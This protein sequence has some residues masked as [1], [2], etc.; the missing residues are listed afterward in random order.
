MVTS[1]LVGQL[2]AKIIDSQSVKHQKLIIAV[3]VDRVGIERAVEFAS[4]VVFNRPKERTCSI[5][6]VAS[7]GEVF[8]GQPLR[9]Y[10]HW[11]KTDFVA[12]ALDAEAHHAL[13]ALDVLLY[14]GTTAENPPL[15]CC[16]PSVT[17]RWMSRGSTTVLVKGRRSQGTHL[18]FESISELRADHLA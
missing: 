7:D 5:S 1:T 2:I 12:L 10:M 4:D 3:T 17:P 15:I 18:R 11:D 8:L 13:A 14:V 9:H 6:S 16:A